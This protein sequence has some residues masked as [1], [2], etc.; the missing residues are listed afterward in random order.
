MK[1]VM[2]GAAACA[3]LL[4]GCGGGLEESLGLGKSSPDE[5]QVVRRAP[6]SV[7]PDMQLRPPRP[8]QVADN[9]ITSE[10][11]V[12]QTIFGASE[13]SRPLMQITFDDLESGFGPSEG[14][15]AFLDRA[16]ADRALPGIRGIVDAETGETVDSNE[17]LIDR[18]MFWREPGD[19]VVDAAAERERLRAD[20]DAGLDST[21]EGAATTTTRSRNPGLLDAIF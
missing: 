13:R 10:E 6:L 5:F 8:G 19:T 18:I 14:E 15:I 21:G 4:T 16:Q 2:L 12:R 9:R 1:P 7:P 17:Y 11:N 3:V 20:A